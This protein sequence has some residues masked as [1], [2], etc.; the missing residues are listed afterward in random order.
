[1]ESAWKATSPRSPAETS[2][3]R[4]CH[5]RAVKNLCPETQ[6]IRT[7]F[8]KEISQSRPTPFK[9][10]ALAGT[11][12][13]PAVVAAKTRNGCPRAAHSEIGRVTPVSPSLIGVSP[14]R[15]L[16][17]PKTTWQLYLSQ[18]SQTVFQLSRIH[19]YSMGFFRARASISVLSAKSRSSSS[20][21]SLA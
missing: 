2:R 21:G 15:H 7:L 20:S 10:G 19:P 18:L 17:P 3:E 6:R 4:D 14:A 9:K 5:P 8:E 13:K 11:Y 16:L 1:M 12:R